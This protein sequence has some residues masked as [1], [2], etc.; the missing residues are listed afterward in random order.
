MP[1]EDVV[2][3]LLRQIAKW[4][5]SGEEFDSLRV[6]GIMHNWEASLLCMFQKESILLY[7]SPPFGQLKFNVDGAAKGKSFPAGVGGTLR[8]SD[9]VVLV[10][11]SKHVGCVE[12][13]EMEVVV[14]SEDFR[15]F[16]S[17]SSQESLILESDSL[18]STS[19]VLTTKFPWRFQFDFNEILSILSS[20]VVR[21][22]H[23]QCSANACRR[24]GYTRGG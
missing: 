3:L 20:L 12:S 5:S 10:L 13:N 19:W 24:F 1:V 14:I 17:S 18:N 7:W 16:A 11:F 4:T 6:N 2:Q 23:V 21:F 8:N 15:I 22:H 9:G